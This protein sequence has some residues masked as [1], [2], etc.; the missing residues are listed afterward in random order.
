VH[1]VFAVVCCQL[2]VLPVLAGL[3]GQSTLQRIRVS[4]RKSIP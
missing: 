1:G 3:G 2:R 4:A